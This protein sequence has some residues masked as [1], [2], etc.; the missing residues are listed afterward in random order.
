MHCLITGVA[1]FVGS[2]LCDRLLQLGHTVRG[3]D[4]FTE[5][6]ARSIKESNLAVARDNKNFSF[7]EADLLQTALDPLL[8]GVDWVFH[9]AAQ[10]GVRASWGNYFDTYTQNNILATQRLLEA[11]VERANRGQHLKKL[12]YASSSSVYGN[13]ERFPT[14]EDLLPMPVSPYGVTKLAAEHLMG[15][16]ASQSNVP[17]VS[18]RY[19][20]VYGPRQRPD[21]AFNRFARAALKKEEIT[22]YGDGEQSRDFT[23]IEDIVAANIL[24]AERG[25]RGAVYNLGGGAVTTMNQALAIIEGITGKLNVVRHSAQRGDARHTS[26]ETK[27]ARTELGFAPKVSLQ[28]GLRRE[29]E[30]ME[31]S[32]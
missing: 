12:V 18:L 24:A 26:A 14:S 29:I 16:Y 1:G 15:L 8:D 32:L 19:F 4:C 17:T 13:A 21:M 6:Y 20:T 30:W 28:E 2:T 7:V 31:K 27:K 25:P 11:V 23:F 3:I 5:Y 9:Q 10:A 22:L